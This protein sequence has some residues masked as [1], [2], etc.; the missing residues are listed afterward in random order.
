[1]QPYTRTVVVLVLRRGSTKFSTK[2]S[3]STL[4]ATNFS[5]TQNACRLIIINDALLHYLVILVPVLE[6]IR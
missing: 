6:C 2:F 1:M 3:S 5:R 4:G